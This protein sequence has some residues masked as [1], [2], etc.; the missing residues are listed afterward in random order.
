MLL[1]T[2]F[3]NSLKEDPKNCLL[4]YRF[5]T[6]LRSRGLYADAIET[7]KSRLDNCNDSLSS[8]AAR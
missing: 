6:L 7:F 5:G 3:K 8:Q 1:I 4:A 2:A